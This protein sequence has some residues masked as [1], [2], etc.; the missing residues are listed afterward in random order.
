M[1]RRL[2]LTLAA[3]A[4]LLAGLVAVERADA[5]P[6][7]RWRRS[8]SSPAGL[9]WVEASRISAEPQASTYLSP[10][11]SLGW[12]SY[13][14]FLDYEIAADGTHVVAQ[15]RGGQHGVIPAQSSLRI[16]TS[17]DGRSWSSKSQERVYETSD[18][19]DP[20][21][22]LLSRIDGVPTATSSRLFWSYNMRYPSGTPSRLA[23][24]RWSDDDGDTFGAA[25]AMPCGD[26]DTGEVY[27]SLGGRVIQGADGRLL[28]SMYGRNW[29]TPGDPGSGAA[30]GYFSYFAASTDG[31]ASWT[32]QNRIAEAAGVQYEEPQCGVLADGNVGCLVRVDASGG[33][34]YR[35][36]C[37]PNG[38]SC[39]TPVYAFPGVG[40]PTWRRFADGTYAALTRD[41]SIGVPALWLSD[42]FATFDG[43]HL[44]GF[45]ADHCPSP[46]FCDTFEYGG[47]VE[48]EA[49]VA[50]IAVSQE[51]SGGAHT[52]VIRA[53]L[54]GTPCPTTTPYHLTRSLQ[55]ELSPSDSGFDLGHTDA[56]NGARSAAVEVW[57]AFPSTVGEVTTP[58]YTGAAQ[59]LF[60]LWDT[61]SNS[62]NQLALRVNGVTRSLIVSVPSIRT[63]TATGWTS[64]GGVFGRDSHNHW[65]V[66]YDGAG[67]TNPERLRVFAVDGLGALSE[68]TGAGTF[69]G[70]IPATLVTPTN[71]EGVVSIGCSSTG[72]AC[73][74]GSALR[75]ALLHEVRAW[76]NPAVDAPTLAAQIAQLRAAGHMPTDPAWAAWGVPGVWLRDRE[77]AAAQVGA[78]PLTATVLGAPAMALNRS[79]GPGFLAH[80]P[81]YHAPRSCGGGRGVPT[82]NGDAGVHADAAPDSGVHPDAAPVD[83]GSYRAVMVK[84]ASYFEPGSLFGLA[85]YTSPKRCSDDASVCA[86]RVRD[87]SVAAAVDT[88]DATISPQI[89]LIQRA[90][91]YVDAPLILIDHPQAGTGVASYSMTEVLDDLDAAAAWAAAQDAVVCPA[92]FI[93]NSGAYNEHGSGDFVGSYSSIIEG[94]RDQIEA[95]IAAE[96][97]AS[98]PGW[99]PTC[100]AVPI[101]VNQGG[102]QGWGQSAATRHNFVGDFVTYEQ[103]NADVDLAGQLHFVELGPD[104]LHPNQTGALALGDLYARSIARRLTDGDAPALVAEA[105]AWDDE[106]SLRV[107]F[108]VPCRE[109]SLTTCVNDP[110]IT[111]NTTDQV[112]Q[113]TGSAGNTALT[114]GVA[115]WNAGSVIDPPAVSGVTVQSC[116]A[117]QAT[118]DVVLDFASAPTGFDEVSLADVAIGLGPA[119]ATGG[120]CNFVS[121]VSGACGDDTPCADWCVGNA[122]L[123]NPFDGG[124]AGGQAVDG[125]SFGINIVGV[126][127]GQAA[128]I[129]AGN[130]VHFD[131]TD[132]IE[133]SPF[134]RFEWV[135]A[136]ADAGS[137]PDAVAGRRS[138]GG[139]WLASTPG[140]YVLG[141]TRSQVQAPDLDA[142]QTDITNGDANGYAT[143]QITVTTNTRALRYIDADALGGGAG[144]IGDPWSWADLVS[145]GAQSNTEY[146]LQ[147]GD[148]FTLTTG[149]AVDVYDADNV[150]FGRYGAG[151]DPVI[152]MPAAQSRDGGTL[153]SAFTVRS[154]SA[155][156]D[157]GSSRVTWQNLDFRSPSTPDGTGDQENFWPQAVSASGRN[158]DSLAFDQVNGDQI[159][160]FIVIDTGDWPEA[161]DV[162]S[163]AEG[164]LLQNMTQTAP[165]ERYAVFCGAN[166]GNVSFYDSTLTTGSWIIWNR[167]YCPR[168]WFNNVTLSTDVPADLTVDNLLSLAA[169]DYAFVEGSTLYNTVRI[170]YEAPDTPYNHVVFEGNTF[171][172]DLAGYETR[173]QGRAY[174]RQ[175]YGNNVAGQLSVSH[176]HLHQ[177]TF[178]GPAFAMSYETD[179]VSDIWITDNAA[180]CMTTAPTDTCGFVASDD[181]VGTAGPGFVELVNNV[182]RVGGPGRNA[183][184]ANSGVRSGGNV[185]TGGRAE[186]FLRNA[187]GVS[188]ASWGASYPTDQFVDAGV[189]PD[190][191]V[192]ADSGVHPDAAVDSGVAPDSGA[193]GS[194]NPNAE[195]LVVSPSQAIT[196]PWDA[197]FAST[198]RTV[199]AWIQHADNG[200]WP[201]WHDGPIG[202]VPPGATLRWRTQEN[203]GGGAGVP[204]VEWS[205]DGTLGGWDATQAFYPS[206]EDWLADTWYLVAVVYDDSGT[207]SAS[208][209]RGS[210]TATAAAVAITT[211][212]A[213][214]TGF[215][216]R[217]G[218]FV[219]GDLG[220]SYFV[221]AVDEFRIFPCVLT[222]ADVEALRTRDLS[223]APTLLERQGAGLTCSAVL[224]NSFDHDTVTASCTGC[225]ADETANSAGGNASATPPTTTTAIPTSP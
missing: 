166:G 12:G 202:Q 93:D 131:F 216:S 85:V 117:P 16:L 174:V 221:G 136:P 56:W 31:G 7:W 64:A 73:A 69:S 138:W 201:T 27:C 111:I 121:E 82:V 71:D 134:D 37:D 36:T 217:T 224:H 118:C 47:L 35:I 196:I 127:G 184:F 223:A 120:G 4:A 163:G 1:G 41:V 170:G 126:D 154:P 132:S 79:P 115:L 10:P 116:P 91:E 191:A 139:G 100:T 188:E 49:G 104:G 8:L 122:Q 203:P 63:D 5:R 182:M 211:L 178:E 44:F 90:A 77:G 112:G 141:V 26:T 192:A 92:V 198:S 6:G 113:E 62:Q 194:A 94:Y 173:L 157:A 14:A 33:S 212:G 168:V 145:S 53:A 9:S 215:G 175:F 180:T 190:A 153:F 186:P 86:F 42:D 187:A 11:Q 165:F 52:Y 189:H 218:A 206:T 50:C 114:Y 176:V 156:P 197:D 225:V 32:Y 152:M 177:N 172:Q 105:F 119:V 3:C 209:I 123:L 60:R 25:V 219:L 15:R 45:D 99:D 199:V 142:G 66:V 70:T 2:L 83:G 169:G 98:T 18:L 65:L 159:A 147:A 210:E 55:L 130:S 17:P 51:I 102:A 155:Q 214:G 81:A 95:H 19:D 23:H 133:S 193:G 30:N 222:V 161:A 160:S 22:S 207:P 72:S 76:A 205:T 158:I 110:P 107:T 21:D 97:A 135:I 137:G 68:I 59:W 125:G 39:G 164:V 20:G 84:S 13:V 67:A 101:N 89:G 124:G 181:P 43:P 146:L 220:T 140:E 144:T 40:R 179:G 80:G 109:D 183:D 58:I 24:V 48:C 75:G 88:P 61:D 204:Y 46:P 148:T 167:F 74:A 208:L 29:V 106:D 78:L 195:A 54:P 128:Q 129:M 103:A 150:L 38:E 162:R 87:G 149:D 34:I 108:R 185:W 28:L 171:T 213:P 57:L 200:G 143:A 96:L 151:A